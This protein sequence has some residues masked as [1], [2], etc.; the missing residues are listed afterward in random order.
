MAVSGTFIPLKRVKKDITRLQLQSQIQYTYTYIK[1]YFD[2]FHLGR[3]VH[4][5]MNARLI[6]TSVNS[7]QCPTVQFTLLTPSVLEAL[8]DRKLVFY[9]STTVLTFLGLREALSLDEI[10]FSRHRLSPSSI[11]DQKSTK[12]RLY[13]TTL[14]KSH[15]IDTIHRVPNFLAHDEET[16]PSREALLAG[17]FLDQPPLLSCPDMWPLSSLDCLYRRIST[18]QIFRNVYP[19]KP[20]F[21]QNEQ[22]LNYFCQIILYNNLHHLTLIVRM[23]ALPLP[24][25]AASWTW[26]TQGKPWA[27]KL[28]NTS[29]G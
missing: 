9:W 3:L 23:P 28:A 13:I 10:C 14:Q 4:F 16:S 8:L 20:W 17:P 7:D 22:K 11:Y 24:H 18:A 5:H 25:L 27:A 6:G 2:R 19:P 21:L 1:Y 29:Y 12:Y 26:K 15:T